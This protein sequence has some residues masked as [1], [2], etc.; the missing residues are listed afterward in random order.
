MR[1]DQEVRTRELCSLGILNDGFSEASLYAF[2]ILIPT[3]YPTQSRQKPLIFLSQPWPSSQL[4]DI[5]IVAINHN[6]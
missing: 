2:H 5:V 3:G 4:L 1:E 6:A